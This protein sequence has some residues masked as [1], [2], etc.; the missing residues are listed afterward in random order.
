MH[1][2]LIWRFKERIRPHLKGY[3]GLVVY[4]DDFV[5]C[6]QYEKEAYECLNHLKKRM[7]HFGLEL[8]KSKTRLIEFGRF[9]ADNRRRHGEGKP[10]TFTF[11]GFTHY[12]SQGKEWEVQSEEES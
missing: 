3:G 10:E 12:C 6:F 5:T 11:L 4:A 9:A 1:Y 7:M 8:E 2:V